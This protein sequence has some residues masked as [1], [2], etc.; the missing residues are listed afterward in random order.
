ARNWPP[1]PLSL[2]GG[3]MPL[4]C[5]G[6]VRAGGLA[7]ADR[8]RSEVAAPFV[9]PGSRLASGAPDRSIR[10]GPKCPVVTE[11]RAALSSR[12]CGYREANDLAHPA[13]RPERSATRG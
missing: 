11:P 8:R 4:R 2:V 6:A 7:T 3:A 5:R 9:A 13:C 12:I 1:Q 10:A